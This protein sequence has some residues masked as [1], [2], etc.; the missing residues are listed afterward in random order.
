VGRKSSIGIIARHELFAADGRTL[1]AAG[2]ASTARNYRRHNDTASDPVSSVIPGQHD[3]ASDFMSQNQGQRVAGRNT[4]VS[5]SNVGMANAAACYPND[6]FVRGN[7]SQSRFVPCELAVANQLQS[8]AGDG[9]CACALREQG[10]H[11]SKPSPLNS[12]ERSKNNERRLP[13]FV[14]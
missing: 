1:A 4:L 13:W 9:G 6:R 7:F 8:F 10:S 5:E 12:N 14:D 3:S 11:S 2:I